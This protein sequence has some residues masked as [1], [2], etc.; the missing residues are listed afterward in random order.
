[1][2]REKFRQ[3]ALKQTKQ[4]KSKSA[5]FLMVKEDR[6]ATEG[7]GNPAFNVSSPDLLAH[8][9]SDRKVIRRDTLDRTLAAHQQKCR[10]LASAEPKGNEYSRN[11]FDP[12]MDEEINPRQCGMEVSREDGTES[13]DI[14]KRDMYK[15]RRGV[16]LRIVFSSSPKQGELKTEKKKSQPFICPI[17]LGDERRTI[18][19]NSNVDGEVSIHR[20][21]LVTEAQCNALDRG[22]YDSSGALHENSASLQSDVDI[23]WKVVSLIA[24]NRLDSCTPLQVD[25]RILNDRLM[26]LFEERGQ[27]EAQ[28]GSRQEEILDSEETVNSRKRPESHKEGSEASEGYVQKNTI[29]LGSSSLEQ[30]NLFIIPIV[31]FSSFYLPSSCTHCRVPSQPLIAHRDVWKENRPAELCTL[32]DVTHESKAAAAGP[33]W[34]VERSQAPQHLQVRMKCARGL[35]NKA[36]RG[37]YRLRVSL[38]GR[39]GGCVFQWQQTEQLKTRTHPV[40]HDGNFYDLGLYFH[41]SLYVALPPKK[42]VKPGMAFLF[43]LCLLRGK[44][45]SFDWVVGWAAFPVCDNNFDVVD[46]KFKCPLLRGHYDQKFDSFRKMEDLM[47]QD[48]DHWLCN[49]YFQVIKLPLCLDDQTTYERQ[50]QLPPEF[51]VSLMAGAETAES[52]VEN[53]AGLSEKQ[54]EENICSSLDGQPLTPLRDPDTHKGSVP[55]D[56]K[57]V[58]THF[59]A[60]EGGRRQPASSQQDPKTQ[61]RTAA[62]PDNIDFDL[63]RFEEAEPAGPCYARISDLQKM[64]HSATP[65][66]IFGCSKWGRDGGV[67]GTAGIQWV[68]AKNAAKQ[69]RKHGAA[70]ITKNDPIQN[71]N[72]AEVEKLQ[73]KSHIIS[74]RSISNK[75]GP[76]PM[77]C[78]LNLL[79]EDRELHKKTLSFDETIPSFFIWPDG[80]APW[81]RAQRPRKE[82]GGEKAA[83]KWSLI[84]LELP[85]DLEV[86]PGQQLQ[87]IRAPDNRI[88][89]F[90]EFLSRCSETTK[91]ESLINHSVKEKSA[92]WRTGELEDYSEDVSYLEELEKHRFS[93]WCSSVADG[94]GS[95]EFFK[96]LHFGMVSAFSELQFAEWRSQGFWFIILLMASLWFLRLYLHYLSQWL[97]LQAI[98]IPVTKF[99]FSPFTVEL[100]YPSSS[101][102]I[103]EE[104]LVVVVGPLMLNAVILPLVLIRWGCQLLFASCPDV[105][106]KL[107]I[108]MGL[109][110]VLDPLAVFIVDTVLGRLTQNGETPIAD[111]AKLYWV[112]VRTMQSGILGVMLTVLI[113]IL[114]FII[115]SL[116]LYLYC[117][118]LHNDSWILDVF[119]RIHS[120]ETKFFIPYDLEIS[121]QELSYIVKRSEQWRGINGD[122]RKVAVYDYIWKNHGFKSRI[123]SCDLQKQN[124]ISVSALGPEDIISHV[125]IYTVYPSGFQ[126]L[127]RHFLRLPS[128]AIVET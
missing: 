7:I 27:G 66:D 58:E 81:S 41:E 20:P 84:V 35:K 79:K 55:T 107:I 89:S 65:G 50:T 91:R 11:Y 54:T 102:A 124:E 116:I 75:F 57:E 128:G 61:M 120:E 72:S 9:T 62:L 23:F 112:F 8:Q 90:W 1:M 31:N 10:L 100:C 93:V 115:S 96:H 82:F 22:L 5:E 38:L 108:T 24:E 48:L 46:G 30:A 77:D 127:Y 119:Q 32:T 85:G 92:A 123:S 121:N 52:G 78:D 87:K 67:E 26:K 2:D 64:R 17:H 76:C 6:E 122:R 83:A 37:S 95:R 16:T 106:S 88:T 14:I 29:L 86:C 18:L 73:D 33:C 53:T 15:R 74:K 113:Y 43:E 40:R 49:L 63:V 68:E 21:D 28:D 44:Y 56:V 109:W 25:T 114:L 125:S 118:R 99:H 42:D 69:F 98:S 13:T 105:L 103:K 3:K 59:N 110:T 104:L 19:L 34:K 101:L 70:P 80:S 36:P 47:C 60:K 51:P 117:L 39:P 12:L 126:E 4:K 97:F 45:A 111:A 71:V 94:T